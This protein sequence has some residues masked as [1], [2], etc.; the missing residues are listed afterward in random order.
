MAVGTDCGNA[1]TERH[2]EWHGHRTGCDTARVE[3]YAEKIGGY[4]KGQSEYNQIKQNEQRRERNAEEHTQQCDHKECADA[5]RNRQNQRLV[6]NG[7]NL[8]CQHLQ[9]RLGDGYNEAEQK[10]EQNNDP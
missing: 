5:D 8:F 2:D 1:D 3:R 10:G 7:W 6:W 9:V 4:E